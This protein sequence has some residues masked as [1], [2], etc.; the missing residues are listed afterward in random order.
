MPTTKTLH[1]FKQRLEGG[2]S[3]VLKKGHTQPGDCISADHYISAVPG[4]LPHTYGCEKDGYYGGTLFVDHA[5][6]KI[7]NFCQFSI[8]GSETVDSKHKLEHFARNEG[9]KIKSYHSDNGIFAKA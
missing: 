7:F 8:T 4:R 6:G 1:K 2:R 9:F 3:K 5:S